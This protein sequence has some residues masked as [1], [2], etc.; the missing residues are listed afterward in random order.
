[1]AA[2]RAMT[3]FLNHHE[4]LGLGADDRGE[5]P[6]DVQRHLVLDRCPGCT[7]HERGTE[8]EPREQ[9]RRPAEIRHDV[10]DRDLHQAGR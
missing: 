3:R 6:D 8:T 9:P 1:M 4:L 5:R 7:R 10:A 2:T